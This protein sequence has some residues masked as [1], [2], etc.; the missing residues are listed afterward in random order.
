MTSSSKD[1]YEILGVPKTA[2]ADEIKKAYR[3]LAIKWHPVNNQYNKQ[4]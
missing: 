4:N 3:K 2:T 1:Y